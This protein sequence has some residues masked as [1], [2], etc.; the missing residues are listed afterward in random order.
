MVWKLILVIHENKIFRPKSPL[1]DDRIVAIFY[2]REDFSTAHAKK[3][4]IMMMM[5]MIVYYTLVF[6]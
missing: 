6:Y 1:F 3:I 2:K 5:M 4:K